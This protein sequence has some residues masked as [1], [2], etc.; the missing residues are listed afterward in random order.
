M[1]VV[2]IILALSWN[3][4]FPINKSLWTSPFVLLTSGVAIV[5]LLVL[6]FLE[7]IPSVNAVL[8]QL[9]PFGKNP[10]FIYTLA[11]MWEEILSLLKIDGQYA[12][13]YFYLQLCKFF[14][15]YNASL[16]YALIHVFIFWCVAK[17]LDKKGIVIAL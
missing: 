11:F 5:V 17:F 14:N 8:I 7:K 1:S 15:E 9:T 13:Y 12:G 3:V 6:T 10:L 2:L 16:V 4:Y